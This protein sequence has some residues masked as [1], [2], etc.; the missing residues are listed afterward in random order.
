MIEEGEIK[1]YDDEHYILA[2]SLFE[3]NWDS[4]Q[5]INW[6]NIS[7]LQFDAAT[8]MLCQDDATRDI[9]LNLDQIATADLR[10]ERNTRWISEEGRN[11]M[12]VMQL[13]MQYFTFA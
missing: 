8:G 2:D 7:C 4:K 6:R 13:G 12:T 1:M 10:K 3:F 5:S 9:L 11:A